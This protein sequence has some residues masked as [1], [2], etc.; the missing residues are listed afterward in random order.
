MLLFCIFSL[1]LSICDPPLL[2]AQQI[3][4]IYP[5]L[6]FL[7]LFSLV[8]SHSHKLLSPYYFL[9]LHYSRVMTYDQNSQ[10]PAY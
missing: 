7:K 2:P 9:I 8:I 1:Q 4:H 3:I 10:F 5:H 6:P